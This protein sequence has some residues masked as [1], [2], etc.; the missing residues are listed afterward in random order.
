M[1]TGVCVRGG[2]AVARADAEVDADIISADIASVD[3]AKGARVMSGI[4]LD[5]SVMT[6]DEGRIGEEDRC[7]FDRN[8]SLWFFVREMNVVA[9]SVAERVAMGN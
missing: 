9:L 7:I 4:L 8:W 5:L 3:G 2:L 6:N 1:H